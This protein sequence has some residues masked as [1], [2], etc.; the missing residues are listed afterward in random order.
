MRI[1]EKE[2]S[3]FVE[4]YDSLVNPIDNYKYDHKKLNDKIIELNRFYK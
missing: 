2:H 4:V 3:G 1:L